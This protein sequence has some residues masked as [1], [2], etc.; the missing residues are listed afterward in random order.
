MSLEAL[1]ESFDKQ[2]EA[3]IAMIKVCGFEKI[4]LVPA[5]NPNTWKLIVIDDAPPL[6][7]PKKSS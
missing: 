7:L 5:D 2:F 1:K 3:A 4:K 6:D